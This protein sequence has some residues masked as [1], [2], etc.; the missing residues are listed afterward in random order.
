MTPLR[1]YLTGLF[2]RAPSTDD[3]SADRPLRTDDRKME[4]K[5][6]EAK[7]GQEG[8]D[9]RALLKYGGGA[10]GGAG[11][12]GGGWF[13]WEEFIRGRTPVET[14]RQCYVALDEGDDET[15]DQLVHSD[16][17]NGFGPGIRALYEQ[18]DITIEETELTAKSDG[19]AEVRMV[20]SG[21]SSQRD[22]QEITVKLR[23]ENGAW[24]LWLE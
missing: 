11:L 2:G 18:N 20:I 24:K 3:D 23:T 13:V 10:A 1:L 6:D 21:A 5:S 15:I 19:R 4:W 8:I 14:A 22:Q 16:S 9:R 17:P 12:L 7:E